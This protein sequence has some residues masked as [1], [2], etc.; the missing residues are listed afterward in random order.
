M[1]VI[2]DREQIYKT[3]ILDVSPP[4]DAPSPDPSEQ[5]APNFYREILKSFSDGVIIMDVNH[6]TVFVG[7]SV[8]DLMGT[9]HRPQAVKM[10][11]NLRNCQQE[12][13]RQTQVA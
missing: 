10:V 8:C 7:S 2:S 4:P 12:F 6:D 11:M 9:S 13:Q 3:P 5:M 1:V